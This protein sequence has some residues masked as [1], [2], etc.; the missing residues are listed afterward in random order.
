ML[1][2]LI[3]LWFAGFAGG[4]GQSGGIPGD[5]SADAYALY[6]SLY[7]AP[8]ALD[9][10][11][12]LLIAADAE[13][14]P[15]SDKRA[16]LRPAKSDDDLMVENLLKFSRAHHVWERRFDFGRPYKLLSDSEV[17]DALECLAGG[18]HADPKQCSPYRNARY[19]RRLS[20]PG[21][22]HDRTRA[23]IMT[24]RRCGRGCGN[25]AMAVYEKASKGWHLE[26]EP[27]ATC[28]WVY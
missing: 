5:V 18:V 2:L 27:F 9:R 24:A 1:R 16:C 17:Q 20:V 8:G 7:S 6:S 11:E 3:P 22:N 28:R 15:A 10:D 26:E 13:T 12:L 4:A 21:F 25:G 14:V 23:L 19:V